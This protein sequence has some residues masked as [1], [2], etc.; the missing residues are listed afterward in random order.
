MSD[1]IKIKGGN[2][3]VP[4]LQD[5]ELAYSKTKKAFFIGTDNGNVKIGDEGWETRIAT[6]EGKLTSIE[7]SIADITARLDALTSS[8]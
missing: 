4:A 5:R 6:I 1:L 8:E 7:A 3:D 2:G